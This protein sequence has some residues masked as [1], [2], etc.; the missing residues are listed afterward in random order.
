MVRGMGTQSVGKGLTS[1]DL[2]KMRELNPGAQIQVKTD[3]VW[4]SWTNGEEESYFWIK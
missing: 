3:S 4:S 1:E 2:E